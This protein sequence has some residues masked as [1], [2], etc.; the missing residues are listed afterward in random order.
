MIVATWEIFPVF[1][2]SSA[3]FFQKQLFQNI[4]SRIPSEGQIVWIHV[5]PYL[6]PNCLQ[7]EIS[8]RH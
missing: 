1:F 7:K 8:R 5:G 4:L 3:D 2:K 6:V